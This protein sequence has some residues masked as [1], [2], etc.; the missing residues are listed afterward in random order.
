[1]GVV[2]GIGPQQPL[3]I[4]PVAQ[5]QR[6]AVAASEV[7]KTPIIALE[8]QVLNIVCRFIVFPPATKEAMRRN[9]KAIVYR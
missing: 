4:G 6:T 3:A 5:P 8:E 7:I 9:L 2:A 1:M